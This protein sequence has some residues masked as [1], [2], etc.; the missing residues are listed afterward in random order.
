[1]I[2]GAGMVAL[3][4]IAVVLA[5]ALL[6]GAAVWWLL[7]DREPAA[8]EDAAW[9][10]E[11]ATAPDQDSVEADDAIA[12]EAPDGR[13]L[14]HALYAL[15]FEGMGPEPLD[16]Q[17]EAHAA[18]GE[19]CA[20]LLA[21]KEFQARHMPRRPQ[22][23]PKLMRAINDPNASLDKI[24]KV[25]GE[26]PALSANLLRI[27]NSPF[28]RVREKPVES[29]V[30]A[31]AMLGLEGLRPVIATALVQPVMQTGDSVF[32]RLPAL[33]WDHTQLSADFASGLMRGARGQEDAF[34]AQMLGLLHGLGAILV[35]QVLR[36]NYALHLHLRPDAQLVARVLDEQAAPMAKRIAEA[37]E[38][39][40]RIDVALDAQM[41]DAL[42]EDPLGRALRA[43][44]VAAALAM[45]HRHGKLGADEAREQLWAWT[46]AQAIDDIGEDLLRLWE[47]LP[48]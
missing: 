39:S 11:E 25:I 42:P 13:A 10:G 1:M 37:W 36:D 47:R 29:L 17:A 22:Q 30:R 12:S 2:G 9:P 18:I 43:G 34:A 16:K 41:L 21:R 15:A 46:Q 23:L 26:D 14:M 31:A 3:V 28:Y 20:N 27:A 33:V 4:W 40:D 32:G 5:L 24:A 7:D 8:P 35:V 45:L 38:L 44:R 19:A 48:S 6:A